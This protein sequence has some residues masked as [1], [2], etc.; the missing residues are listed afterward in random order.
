MWSILVS[1]DAWR[2]YLRLVPDRTARRPPNICHWY[3]LLG[4]LNQ[5]WSR[6]RCGKIYLMRSYR[7]LGELIFVKLLLQGD[8]VL[9]Q[10]LLL[11]LFFSQQMCQSSRW[12]FVIGIS[13]VVVSSA[14][15]VRSDTAM[16]IGHC[17]EG[18]GEAAGNTVWHPVNIGCLMWWA[19]ML[20]QLWQNGLFV[21]LG[22]VVHVRIQQISQTFVLLFDVRD[23]LLLVGDFV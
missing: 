17:T 11:T 20:G 8:V 1:K 9:I 18:R 23:H 2:N 19:I 13:D 21:V 7:T 5:R 4:S 16:W 14:R 15:S 6:F 12:L 3:N 22:P 10:S